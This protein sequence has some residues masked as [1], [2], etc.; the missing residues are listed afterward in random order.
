MKVI[1][2]S[3]ESAPPVTE[4]ESRGAFA[5]PLANGDGESHVYFVRFDAGGVIGPHPAGFD[6]LF[7]VTSG[8]GWVV[9]PDGLRQSLSAGHAAAISRGEVHSKGSDVG[10]T[11]IMIQFERTRSLHPIVR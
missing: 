6:Q 3:A 5:Q 4:F 2:F 7:L 9:G 8:S 11:A 1:A 10:L